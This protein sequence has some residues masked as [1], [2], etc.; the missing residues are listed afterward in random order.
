M[1]IIVDAFGGDNAPLEIIKGAA[2]AVSELGAEIILT[3]SKEK[4][5]S[6][7]KDNEISL[8]NIEIK[9]CSEVI[10]MCDDPTYVLKKKK[11]SS[12]S[13]GLNMLASGEGEAFVS[14]GSTAALVVGATLLV[15]RLKGVKRPAL[16]TVIPGDKK[17]SLVLDVGANAVCR[18]QMLTQFAAMGSIYM[19]KVY[20][21]EN[22]KVGLVNI[23]AERTKGTPLQLETYEMLEKTDLNFVGN[24]EPRDIPS[25]DCDVIVAD[26]FTGNVI[27][28][29]T[30]GVAK[31][32]SK[33][34]KAIFMKNILTKLSSLPLKEGI[35]EFKKSMD[36]SE[37]GGAP[38]LGTSKPVIKAHGSSDA[39][40]IKNA[41][42]QAIR[43]VE[44]NMIDKIRGD[45][46][47]LPEMKEE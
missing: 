27:L 31:T 20:G 47:A 16:A 2:W 29:L 10:E 32:F 18:P 3:G 21:V 4:I 5:E 6:V 34:I 38:L 35:S 25:T 19:N 14:A 23:G 13:V 42:R 17:N 46:A 45:L 44:S 9:D 11:D 37:H 30:E 33:R 28:K 36:Y 15:K 7:A 43:C 26:G 41:I 8:N 24:I 39:K 12:M 22:P 40:A 1:K